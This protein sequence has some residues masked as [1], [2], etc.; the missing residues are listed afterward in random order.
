MTKR[1]LYTAAIAALVAVIG[2]P[3]A[4]STGKHAT[5][6]SNPQQQ[7]SAAAAM[8][9]STIEFNGTTFYRL[10][11]NDPIPNSKDPCS[12]V[13][14]QKEKMSCKLYQASEAGLFPRK[15]TRQE[16]EQVAN[17]IYNISMAFKGIKDTD[18]KASDEICKRLTGGWG[19]LDIIYGGG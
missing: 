1:W 14:G 10:P 12:G 5:I 18:A 15:M 2:L 8:N 7:D 13:A 11:D 3:L 17:E 6:S 16:A 9:S 19:C 4:C